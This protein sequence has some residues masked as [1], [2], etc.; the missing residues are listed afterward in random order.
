MKPVIFFEYDPFFYKSEDDSLA[1]FNLL[2]KAGYRAAIF[3]ENTGDYLLTTDL[4]NKS[5]IADLHYYFSGRKMER[6][7]DIIVFHNEDSDIANKL[8]ESEI[9]YFSNIRNYNI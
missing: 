6:Y 8:R 7:C 3:Y 4:S 9:Q 2:L 5:L 1:V